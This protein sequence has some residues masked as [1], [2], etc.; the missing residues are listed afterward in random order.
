MAFV[1]I[2]KE[3][4]RSVKGRMELMRAAELKAIDISDN[5][6]ANVVAYLSTERFLDIAFWG[7]HLHL[8]DKLPDE[9]KQD[10]SQYD[11]HLKI[12]LPEQER[13]IKRHFKCDL[14]QK[15]SAPPGVSSWRP[16][17]YFV[18]TE[19]CAAELRKIYDCLIAS[20]E[21]N[22]RWDKAMTQ[23]GNFL[24]NCKSLNEALKLWP[25]VNVYIPDNYTSKVMAQTQR[26][27]RAS[28]AL[29]VLK[30]IDTQEI[31]A[32]A[33]IARLSGADI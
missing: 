13:T 1:G 20:H 6:S 18:M 32:Q 31:Q 33:V 26:A 9:W 30:T 2:T 7:E 17:L 19:N 25:D 23:V 21:V 3:L 29:D 8:K 11:A 28:A 5:E 15:Y 16:D 27:K 24:E 12:E 22:V 14:P 10:V 4:L